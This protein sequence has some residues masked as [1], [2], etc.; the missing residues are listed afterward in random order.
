[1]TDKLLRQS[2]VEDRVGL[3]KSKIYEMIAAGE[4][5]RPLKLGGVNVWPE[6]QIGK[7]ITDLIA[8]N[9]DTEIA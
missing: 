1:M 7:W 9:A 4:F 5:P 6:S 3:K 2:A 8:A